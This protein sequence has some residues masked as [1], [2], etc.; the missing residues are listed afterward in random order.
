MLINKKSEDLNRICTKYKTLLIISGDSGKLQENDVT[1][2]P[3]NH[4]IIR[5][6][7]QLPGGIPHLGTGY[8]PK[9]SALGA[10]VT[11]GI[12]VYKTFNW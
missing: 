2:G 7:L 9:W 10:R 3:Q 11:H 5:E 8:I 6:C 1:C 4:L 12:E